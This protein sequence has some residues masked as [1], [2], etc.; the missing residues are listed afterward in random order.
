MQVYSQAIDR[1]VSSRY[2][3]NMQVG[4]YHASLNLEARNSPMEELP[5]DYFILLSHK[6]YKIRDKDIPQALRHISPNHFRF[7][8]RRAIGRESNLLSLSRKGWNALKDR[9]RS[10]W[11]ERDLQDKGDMAWADVE[12]MADFYLDQV[13]VLTAKRIAQLTPAQV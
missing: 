3:F 1:A 9:I 4:E 8:H 13:E 2:F 12:L 6:L 7:F 11:D 5:D 10:H